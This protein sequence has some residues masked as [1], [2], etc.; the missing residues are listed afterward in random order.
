MNAPTDSGYYWAKAKYETNWHVVYYS[1]SMSH[2]LTA[3]E[4]V[5]YEVS[6]FTEWGERIQR[7]E[8]ES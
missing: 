5:P 1:Q 4:D 3:G 2:V 7:K 8:D 6:D